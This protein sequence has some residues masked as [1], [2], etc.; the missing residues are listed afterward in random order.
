MP[1]IASSCWACVLKMEATGKATA[2]MGLDSSRIAWWK[3]ADKTPIIAPTIPPSPDYTPASPDY[4]PASDSEFD[5]SEDPSSDHIPP[6]P[7]IPTHIISSMMKHRHE[8]F[9]RSYLFK[10][11]SSEAII[12]FSFGLLHLFFFD[13]TP[14]V[15]IIPSPDLPNLLPRLRELR[16]PGYLADVRGLN[17]KEIVEDDAID[18][19]G[20]EPL[21]SSLKVTHIVIQRNI[22]EPA[23]EG[24]V[25]A[26]YET[27]G[28]L[29]QRF[30]DHT[31][32]IPVH[33]IQAI[34]GV[35]REQG[36]RMVGVETAVHCL[37]T[38]RLLSLERVT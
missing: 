38:E 28:D 19:R 2:A 36:H 20:V 30:H 7:T 4:S 8:T 13:D 29:V 31:Q 18:R 3:P 37:M 27:L 24:A 1:Q 16:I 15:Q 26:T 14:I 12:R 17:H 21:R 35:Q 6:L 5:P 23:Q 11:S 10:D 33:R 9:C 22:P 25:E 32:T 34:E